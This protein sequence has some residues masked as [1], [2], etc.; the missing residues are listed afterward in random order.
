VSGTE[1]TP[2]SPLV[3]PLTRREREILVYLDEGFSA[4][5][6]AEQL[7]LAIS[8][9]KFHIQNVYGKLGVNTKRQALTRAKTLGLLGA[10]AGGAAAQAAGA[11]PLPTQ[12]TQP[13]APGESPFKG[14]RYYDE[15]NAAWFFG[16]ETLAAQLVAR[17]AGPARFLAVVGASGSDKSSIVRAGVL[18]ALRQPAAPAPH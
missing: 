11:P 4:P 16:R 15:A 13:P 18:P 5:E 10:D 14:L 12:I 8:S 6:I 17:L 9:V 1:H 2:D 7:S 3:E